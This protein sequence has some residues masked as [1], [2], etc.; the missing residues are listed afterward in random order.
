MHEGDA[1]MKADG[2]IP[3]ASPADA[4]EVR[5]IEA[6]YAERDRTLAGSV[7][8]DQT[9]AGNQWLQQEHRHRLEQIL[10]QRFGSGLQECR[11]LD[12]GCGYGSLLHWFHQLG[13]PAANLHGIDLLP[14]R[15]HEARRIFPDFTFAQANAASSN[16]ADEPFDLVCVFTVFSS[17]LDRGMAQ[18]VAHNMTRAL[19]DGGAVVWYDVRYPNPWNH[20]LCAMTKRRIRGLFPSFDIQVESITVVPPLA[21]LLGPRTERAYPLLASIPVLRSHYLGLLTPSRIA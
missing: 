11:V 1:H 8:R 18:A 17:I 9:N 2:A 6:A 20:H 21:R 5:R 10:R 16:F 7:K 3:V 12:V 15:I 14:K 19:R 4:D 13:V